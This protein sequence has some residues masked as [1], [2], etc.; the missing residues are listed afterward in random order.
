VYQ[1]GERFVAKAYVDRKQK[2]LGTYDTAKEAALAFDRAAVQQ[3][4]P[5][6]RLNYPDGLPLDDE[7]YEELMNPKKKRRLRS[8]NTTGY[9]GVSKCGRF[10][11]A[12]MYLKGKVTGLGAYDSPKEAALAFD[13]TAVQHKRPALFLN[14]PN[15][16]PIDDEELMHPKKRRLKSTNT[17]GYNGVSKSGNN[18]MSQI[19]VEG[20][21]NYLG[22]FDTPKEAALA[23]DRAIV[24]HK[25]SSSKLNYPDGLPLDD[26]DYEALMNPTK[27]R[28]L[29]SGNT[30]GYRG[31]T[32]NG[33]RFAAKIGVKRKKLY[34]GTYN[35][36]KEAA[37]AYDRAVVHHK[38]SSS[39]LN[40]PNDATAS[41]STEYASNN[42]D[43]ASDAADDQS[44]GKVDTNLQLLVAVAQALTNTPK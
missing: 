7:D 18:Y 14:Y 43:E 44:D 35:T 37:V 13:R 29:S 2:H 24:H 28:R 20:K 22:T 39:K 5:S 30:M 31:V 4:L 19:R 21:K 6:S 41:T 38:I 17:T 8:S 9:N 16:L 36:A 1:I 25:L 27:K 34:L 40:F 32:R 12:Q 23:F 10:F 3:K 26:E 15:G 42:D 33:K 11:I